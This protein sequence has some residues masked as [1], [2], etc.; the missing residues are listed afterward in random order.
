MDWYYF[1]QFL[2]D[3]LK[4]FEKFIT[5]RSPV[6]PTRIFHHTVN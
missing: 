1:F 2:I 5:S 4:K 3:F 6:D